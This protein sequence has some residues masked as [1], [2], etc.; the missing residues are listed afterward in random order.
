MKPEKNI[1]FFQNS[2][3]YRRLYNSPNNYQYLIRKYSLFNIRNVCSYNRE[4][5]AN[6]GEKLEIS[7]LLVKQA[8]LPD[9]R[10]E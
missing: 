9:Q 4:K 6:F 5:I 1:K 2:I 8:N 3:I 10:P 7:N